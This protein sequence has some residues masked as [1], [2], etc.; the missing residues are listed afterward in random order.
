MEIAGL[1]QSEGYDILMRLERWKSTLLHGHLPDSSDASWPDAI[2]SGELCRVFSQLKLPKLT[3]RHE[4]LVRPVLT[5][6][7]DMTLSYATKVAEEDFG[8]IEGE[9]DGEEEG[10]GEGEGSEEGSGE[11][12][13]E[14]SGEGE[15]EGSGEGS[16]EGVGEGEGSEE[17]SG[18]GLRNKNVRGGGRGSTKAG[19]GG[20]DSN[21]S[22][23][24][25]TV[26]EAV[27]QERVSGGARKENSPS[28]IGAAERRF[29]ENLAK[30]LASQFAAAWAPKLEDLA[31]LDEMYGTDHDIIP[32][33]VDR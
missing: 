18:E 10:V 21:G 13:G 1:K 32:G 15:G 4:A 7:L 30:Q 2:L 22:E 3:M 11:G 12:L 25:K 29:R 27:L 19:R 24:T 14:G 5:E 8:E 26:D 20:W 28:P 31:S 6:L 16:G 23:G 9:E 33:E 17:G